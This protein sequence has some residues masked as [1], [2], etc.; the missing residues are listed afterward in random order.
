MEKEREREEQLKT[1]EEIQ[2]EEMQPVHDG[3]PFFEPEPEGLIIGVS[4][5]DLV[6][7]YSKK[8]RP[9][10]DCLNMNFYEGQITSFL[11]HNG[12]GKTTTLSIL[13][14]LFP[15]TS[16]TAYIYGQDI[17]TEMDAIRQSLGMC[18]QYNILFN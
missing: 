15:P 10:V 11:G 4:V 17:R 7:V 8:S 12:A 2:Q 1:Q 16:G 9:A 5:Q 3:N 18:P 6:K 13:T 14:G